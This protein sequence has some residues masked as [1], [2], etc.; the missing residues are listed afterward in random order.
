MRPLVFVRLLSQGHV[1]RYQRHYRSTGHVWQGRFT[2]FP[3]Q[4]DEHPLVVLRSIERNPLRAALVDRAEMWPW[5]SLGTG[6]G[7]R[8]IPV[9]HPG[10][11]ARGPS[12]AEALSAPRFETEV[13]AIRP[14][15]SRDTPLGSKWWVNRTVTNLGLESSLHPR[16]NPRLPLG[17]QA[18][19]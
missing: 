3:I 18:D 15:L 9:L 12:W 14:C 2:A 19:G 6:A 16:G 7:G 5:S 1:R 4:E 10:P 8:V 11:V 17:R 13:E